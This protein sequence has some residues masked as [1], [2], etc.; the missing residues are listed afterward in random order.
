MRQ[1]HLAGGAGHGGHLV[2]ETADGNERFELPV[3]AAL[4]AALA[5][6]PP[7]AQPVGAPTITARE[8]QVRVRAGEEPAELAAGHNASLDWIMR[9]AAPVLDERHRVADEA[10]RGRAR[11]STTDGE[12]VVFG[13]AVSDRFAAHGID[14][15]EVSWDAFR[16]DDGQWTITATWT[17]AEHEHSAEWSFQLAARTLTPCDDAA[18]DLLSDRPIRP[19]V[20]PAE[21][22]PARSLSLAPPLVPGVVAFPVDLAPPRDEIFDQETLSDDAPT[23]PPASAGLVADEPADIPLPIQVPDVDLATTK[24]PRLTNV[25]RA[26]D[27]DEDRASR[28]SIPSWDD[29]LLGVRRKHD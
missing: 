26:K 2:L 4:H 23:P 1:L 22:E 16:R 19:L 10:R 13:E 8:V 28:A 24:I 29:I 3:D 7:P 11:R 25:S 15:A 21:P 18:A 27:S 20:P 6:T 14:P 5:A 17:R 9:F 12:S